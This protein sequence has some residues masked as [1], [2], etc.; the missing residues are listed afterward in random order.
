MAKKLFRYEDEMLSAICESLCA[1]RRSLQLTQAE[2]ARLAGMQRSY[3]SDVENGL[4]N[5]S[6]KNLCRI[7]FALNYSL[8]ELASCAQ[9]KVKSKAKRRNT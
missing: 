7:A 4:R 1:R 9:G 3:I 6:V 5:L 8:P 2:V